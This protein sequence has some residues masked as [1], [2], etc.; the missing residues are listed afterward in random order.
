MFYSKRGY[1]VS[2]REQRAI[3]ATGGSATYGELLPHGIHIL[4]ELLVGSSVVSSTGAAAAAATFVDIGSGLGRVVLQLALETDDTT[5]ARL[6]G[7]EL[8]GSRHEQAEW[9]LQAL[10]T[11]LARRV[12]FVQADVTT[13]ARGV[14]Q[15]ATHVFMC[16]TAFG[17][18]AC[19]AVVDHLAASP[20][21][22]VLV[23]SRELPFQSH[24]IKLGEAGPCPMSWND[25]GTLHVYVPRWVLEGGGG[26]EKLLLPHL[27]ARF[28]SDGGMVWLP[29]GSGGRVM[30][31]H[32][33]IAAQE[34]LAGWRTRWCPLL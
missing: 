2:P 18:S 26:T 19:R 14:L 1:V 24:L 10:T 25:S 8:A 11:S 20:N 31:P 28:C 5:L 13:G 22:R 6:I 33:P 12:E 9:V 3:D 23:T 32:L 4:R 29:W 27:A 16:S 21:F 15:A 34:P 30:H 17:A 7:V